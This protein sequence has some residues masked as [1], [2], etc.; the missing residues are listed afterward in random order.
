MQAGAA[1]SLGQGRKNSKP[2]TGHSM[3]FRRVPLQT[4]SERYVVLRCEISKY[5]AS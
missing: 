4:A 5:G 2:K 3:C 1:R